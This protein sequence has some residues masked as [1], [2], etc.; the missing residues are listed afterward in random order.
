MDK[1]NTWSRA[2]LSVFILFFFFPG[3]LHAGGKINSQKKHTWSE[4][5]GWINFRSS[6]G[7][8]TVHKTHLSGWAWAENIGWIKL[9]ADGGGPYANSSADDWGVNNDGQGRLSGYAWSENVGWINF[10]PSG[11]QVVISSKGRFDGYAWAENIGWIHFKNDDPFYN[12]AVTKALP[13]L[14]PLLD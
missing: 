14:T 6:H 10:H 8:V 5:A 4:N 11:S 2:I 1:K 3:I 7:E 12:V 9:G 13:F